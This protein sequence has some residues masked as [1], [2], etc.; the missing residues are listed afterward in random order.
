MDSRPLPGELST[1]LCARA[2]LSE[3]LVLQVARARRLRPA[4]AD[5]GD[6][7]GPP[8]IRLSPH[9]DHAAPRRLARQQETDSP[10]VSPRRPAGADACATQ[11]AAQST[12]WRTAPGEWP[13]SSVEHGLRPRPAR[14]RTALPG[15]NGH[16]SMESREC[17]DGGQRRA[18]RPQRRR[19]PRGA[20]L[21]PP[22]AEDHHRRSWHRIHVKGSPTNGPTNEVSPWPSS[23]RASLSRM[24]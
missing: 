18:D 12:A 15:L 17:P 10:L 4:D 3:Y 9:L 24:R 6:R 2:H 19:C 22:A 11:E 7:A 23:G 20:V 5:S 8:A 1:G 13:R 16:R 21:P 14:H